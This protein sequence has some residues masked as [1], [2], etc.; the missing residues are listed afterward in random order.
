LESTSAFR[1]T[2]W[3]LDC[4]SQSGDAAI[5]YVSELQWRRLRLHYTA[6]LELHGGLLETRTSMRRCIVRTDGYACLYLDAPAIA[7]RGTWSAE[8]AALEEGLF[9][10]D[11]GEVRW[12]CVQPKASVTIELGGH[13]LAGLGY[14]ERLTL[15]IPPWRLPLRRLQWGRF[16]S[17][18]ASIVWID[19]AGDFS[20]RWIWRNGER[21]QASIVDE[22]RIGFAR[23]ETLSL[24]R[25]TTL[26]EG[27]LG[28]TI[29]PAA[30]ALRRFFPRAIFGVKE[31]KWL[32]TGEYERG[33][34]RS[35][36]W[37]IHEVVDWT[38]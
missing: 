19:W 2:K 34:R 17:E 32:S 28:T 10:S 31:H 23:D 27:Q 3:Y 30:P 18:D 21:L 25:K 22:S 8:Q 24:D 9:R 11:E 15:T 38:V 13:S 37:A 33:S 35:K 5:L 26:R 1:L 7:A 14:A 6:L 12:D 16:L 20:G 4:V 29:L 36:G